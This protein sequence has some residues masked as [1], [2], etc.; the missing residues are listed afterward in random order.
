MM[1]EFKF[2]VIIIIIVAVVVV[3]FIN[4]IIVYKKSISIR[5]NSTD[6]QARQGLSI[7][8]RSQRHV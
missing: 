8:K 6:E 3:I 5:S 4:F 1:S 7:G 2:V